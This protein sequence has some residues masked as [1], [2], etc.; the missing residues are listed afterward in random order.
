MIPATFVSV[1]AAFYWSRATS[2]AAFVS[3]LAGAG[4]GVAWTFWALPSLSPTLQCVLEPALVGIIV[5]LVILVV[6]SYMT[7]EP[8]KSQLAHFEPAPI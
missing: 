6:L 4:A 1:L 3:S 7:P 2:E 8:S 5:S